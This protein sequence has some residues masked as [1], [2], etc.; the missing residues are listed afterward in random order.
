M[1]NICETC[2]LHR[3]YINKGYVK[4]KPTINETYVIYIYVYVMFCEI[5]CKLYVQYANICFILCE[6]YV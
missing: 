5:V 6:T 2:I 1:R 4:H 3:L